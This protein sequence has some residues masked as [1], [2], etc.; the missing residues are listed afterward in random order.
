MPELVYAGRFVADMAGVR[1]ARVRDGIFDMDG[2]LKDF[3]ELGSSNLPR[4]IKEEFGNDVRRLAK[5]PFVVVYEYRPGKDE[6]HVLG[7]IH[8]RAAY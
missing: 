8:G 7:L 1:S 6:V 4:S 2:L 3:P 5:D